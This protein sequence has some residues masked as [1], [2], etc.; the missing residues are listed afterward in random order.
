MH[1][2]AFTCIRVVNYQL[3]PKSWRDPR[4]EFFKQGVILGRSQDVE[5]FLLVMVP[6]HLLHLIRKTFLSALRAPSRDAL[7]LMIVKASSCTRNYNRTFCG[8][9]NQIYGSCT[10]W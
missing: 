5:R 3:N 1:L 4:E 7:T 10:N 8:T 2:V 9:H 6:T